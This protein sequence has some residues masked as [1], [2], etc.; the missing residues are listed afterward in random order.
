MTTQISDKRSGLLADLALA[1]S[2][3]IF[4][5]GLCVALAWIAPLELFPPRPR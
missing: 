5:A 3:A 1:A 2:M 4:I